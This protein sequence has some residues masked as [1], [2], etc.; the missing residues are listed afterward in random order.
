MRAAIH[1]CAAVL[2]LF[3]A[4][5]AGAQAV[6][7]LVEERPVVPITV[8]GLLGERSFH[9]SG[10]LARP[11]GAG[12]FPIA[13][14]S[15][16]SPRDGSER[17]RMRADAAARPARELARRGWAALS[18]LRRGYG[19][20]DGEFAEDAGRCGARD[21]AA[22][23][24]ESAR[25]LAAAVAW[26]GAQPWADRDRLLLVGVS[27]GGFAS[28][29]LAAQPPPGLRAVVSFAGGR[30]SR[31][32]DDVCQPDRLVAAFRAFGRT[33]R[34]PALWIYARNDLYFG[35]DLARA[36]HAAF[37]EGGA[38]AE[39]HLMPPWGED[40]HRLYGGA[41]DLWWPIVD[42]FLARHGLR[43]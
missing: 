1:L 20:S 37:T 13:L 27:A 24:R 16:G 5:R 19:T 31:G 39:L 35:P 18:V 12:P 41:P 32:P 7:E 10:Y 11:S 21:Y 30:G 29:A 42:D 28:T 6:V 23:G 4:T 22:A 25:D 3:A 15:H 9:L 40:G 34:V 26:L 36:M 43:N 33:A 38:P 2:L 14:L 8:P 17:R